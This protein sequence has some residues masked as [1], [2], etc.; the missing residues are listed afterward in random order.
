MCFFIRFCQFKT[1][2]TGTDKDA[3]FPSAIGFLFDESASLMA[4]GFTMR[5]FFSV[6]EIYME[7]IIDCLVGEPGNITKPRH[8]AQRI[9]EKEFEV[10]FCFH[11]K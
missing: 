5:V 11:T 1:G 4:K 7:E 8:L 6:V 10:T 2:Q 9:P 3:L